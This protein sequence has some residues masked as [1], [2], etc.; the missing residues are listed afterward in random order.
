[1]PRPCPALWYLRTR[2]HP[3]RLEGRP[4]AGAPR[5]PL[6]AGEE[7]HPKQVR[8]E[9][10]GGTH[11]RLARGAHLRQ[12]TYRLRRPRSRR[13]LSGRGTAL[14][15]L[16]S[17]SHPA[18]ATLLTRLHSQTKKQSEGSQK[19][20]TSLSALTLLRNSEGVT[21]KCFLTYWAKNETLENSKSAAISLILLLECFSS[22]M[23]CS[24]AFS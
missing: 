16:S 23:I 15:P 24:M 2:L 6:D 11:L 20:E 5:H 10:A 19:A 8:L 22:C 7:P 1:M 4:R 17:Y 9:S 18:D 14:R 21:P 12:R 13:K 3:R